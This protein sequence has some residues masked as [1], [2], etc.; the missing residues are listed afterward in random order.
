MKGKKNI[1]TPASRGVAG[2][3]AFVSSYCLF[4]PVN[5]KNPFPALFPLKPSSSDYWNPPPASINTF[6]FAFFPFVK[7]TQAKQMQW[8]D[9]TRFTGPQKKPQL[10]FLTCT[11]RWYHLF[12]FLNIN[13]SL[14]IFLCRKPVCSVIVFTQPFYYQKG[15][16]PFSSSSP[17]EDTL[18]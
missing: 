14:F 15:F 9:S 12:F 16:L 5:W 17:S 1:L 7:L 11:F 8:H 10:S 18:L 4:P 6:H 2:K 3:W 13:H